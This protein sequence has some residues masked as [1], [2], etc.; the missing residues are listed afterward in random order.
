M[1]VNKDFYQT[2]Y[3]QLLDLIPFSGE[4]KKKVKEEGK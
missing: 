1:W 4:Q 3:D 2:E